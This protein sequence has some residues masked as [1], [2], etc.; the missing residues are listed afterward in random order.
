MAAQED[1]PDNDN[2]EIIIKPGGPRLVEPLG[3]KTAVLLFASSHLSYR[4]ERIKQAGAS[5]DFPE[6][7]PHVS[8]TEEAVDLAEVEPYRGK[9]VLGPEVF[10]EFDGGDS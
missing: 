4:H 3:S 1:W 10:E 2:G 5:W 8:L 9:I 7:Q 6:F